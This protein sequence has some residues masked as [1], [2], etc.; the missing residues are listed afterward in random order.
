MAIPK[1]IING[2]LEWFRQGVDILHDPVSGMRVRERYL[3]AGDNL[4]GLANYAYQNGINFNWRRSPIVS[5]VELNYSGGAVGMPDQP[6]TNWQ[7]LCNEVQ[8]SIY[9]SP[10]VSSLSDDAV[11]LIKQW[12]AAWDAGD[13]D[14]A[15]S[16]AD[17]ASTAIPAET[18]QFNIVINLLKR[19]L[20]HYSIGQYVA[21]RTITISLFYNG[22]LPGEDGV[23]TIGGVDAPG[24]IGTKIA[25]IPTPSTAPGFTWGWRQLPSTMTTTAHNRVEVATEWWLGFWPTALYQ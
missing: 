25:S 14:G 24:I 9:L 17:S 5:S 18:D 11:N 20:T 13:T 22:S 1:V 21:K 3:G 10:F 23:N 15:K 7:L 16:I 19:G 6:Q 12:Q 2:S 8:E 4:S